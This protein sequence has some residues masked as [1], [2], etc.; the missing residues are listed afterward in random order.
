MD[1]NR[2]LISTPVPHTRYSDRA[3]RIRWLR[4]RSSL[5]ARLA[6]AGAPPPGVAGGGIVPRMAHV[7]IVVMETH[8]Y[9]EVPTLPYTSSL[10]SKYTS[11]SQS[12]AVT[13]P[14]QP[15]YLALWA[16]STLGNTDDTCPP[17]GSPFTASNLGKSCEAA[18][19]TWKSRS[20]E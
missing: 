20:E 12:F 1:P 15:N 18:G 10:I 14:S 7:I 19:L 5:A 9:D 11:F 8:S 4:R 2:C 13:H 16:A 17:P 3:A 6:L